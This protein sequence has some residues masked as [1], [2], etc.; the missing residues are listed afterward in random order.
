MEQALGETEPRKVDE[1]LGPGARADSEETKVSDDDD[2]GKCVE[3]LRS[4]AGGQ[5]DTVCKSGEIKEAE[6]HQ[7]AS[8]REQVPDAAIEL[9]RL[10][11]SIVSVNSNNAGT[12]AEG[13]GNLKES[14]VP[15]TTDNKGFLPLS[16]L[17]GDRHME[18][19][20]NGGVNVEKGR[21]SISGKPDCVIGTHAYHEYRSEFYEPK[22]YKD[23][24]M[25][26]YLG[27]KV[28]F[29]FCEPRARIALNFK[30]SLRLF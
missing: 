5:K 12:F 8:S 24:M 1:R 19:G 29:L 22:D 18:G 16:E 27:L 10:L 3:I 23:A 20:P 6:P 11:Q 7:V 26:V 13:Y 25:K 21:S 2:D 30:N 4:L 9:L 14:G 17:P 28:C 15:T